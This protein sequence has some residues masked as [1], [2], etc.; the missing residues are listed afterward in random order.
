MGATLKFANLWR[1]IREIDLQAIRSA[2]LTPFELWLVEDAASTPVDQSTTS[3]VADTARA[4]RLG[5]ALT[6]DAT[7]ARLHPY[8]RRVRAADVAAMTA[9]VL[10]AAA[11]VIAPGPA[12]SPSIETAIASLRRHRVPFV[13]VMPG[14]D[15]PGERFTSATERHVAAASEV[16]ADGALDPLL[17]I[18]LVGVVS[19]DVRLALGRH[20]PALRPAVFAATIDETAKANASYALTTGFAEIVPVLT[21]PLNLGDMIVLTKNQL[22]MSYRLVLAAGRDGEP[23]ALLG[24]ILGVLGGGLLFRQLARQLVGLIPI[25]GLVPKVAIAYGGTWAIGRA[26]ELWATEGREVTGDLVRSLSS[27]GLQRGRGVATRLVEQARAQGGRTAARW[28][29]LKEH[30]PVVG[31]RRRP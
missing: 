18:A 19:A 26:I 12:A 9:T 3:L 16:T 24:E 25:A 4:P 14:Q 23:R 29:R 28:T 17:A 27:E 30:L 2:A 21:A 8:L 11:I 20:F 22:M 13:L 7:A 15:R 6:G 5:A 31:R 10:P 1:V